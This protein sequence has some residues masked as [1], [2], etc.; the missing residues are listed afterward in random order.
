MDD[1][2]R[3][4]EAVQA[5]MN[6]EYC[7]TF[8]DAEAEENQYTK[9]PWGDLAALGV[10]F[11][12]MP[13][14][15]RT[16]TETVTT[17]LGPNVFQRVDGLAMDLVHA[18]D[19]PGLFR[20]VAQNGSYLDGGT[21]FKPLAAAGAVKEVTVPFDPTAV[22]MAAALM[23]INQKLD[24]IQE[25]QKEI[26]DYLKAQ[27]RAK[28]KG[29]LNTL[30]DVLNNY[31][32]NWDNIMYMTNQHIKV[33]DIKQDA[34]QSIILHRDQIGKKR[35]KKSF[36]HS[37]QEVQKKLQGIQSELK[38]YQ[39]AL[40]VFGFASFLEVMLLK[41]FKK[42]YLDGVVAKIEAYSLKYRELYTDCYNEL[43]SESGSS[44]QT[45]LLGGVAHIT[46]GAGDVIAK[47]PV[48]SKGQL[49]EALIDA[50]ERLGKTKEGKAS[51][52]M[53]SLVSGQTGM[54]KPFID[55]INAV[56][57]LYNEP[58]EFYFNQ[59]NLYLRLPQN[60]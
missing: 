57:Q 36:L 31:K 60:V 9:V 2:Q 22:L 3:N 12:S 23:S 24:D 7:P 51:K 46:K 43:E 4:D 45:A 18:K 15:M 44:I 14:A 10:G 20:G 5:M 33:L 34:E 40:Y 21:L 35:G 29:D 19:M 28:L 32:Y 8:E 26:L 42:E 37:D 52:Q 38:D 13:A 17:T 58:L 25:M 30:A 11:A 27:D 53:Q 50:G 41:N 39:M 6:V 56:K 47:I 54:V 59:E 48:I 55:N 1:L 49:D 16:I